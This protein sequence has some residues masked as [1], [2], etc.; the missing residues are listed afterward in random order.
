M[1]MWKSPRGTKGTTI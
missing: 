1:R